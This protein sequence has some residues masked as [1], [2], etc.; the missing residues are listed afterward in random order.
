MQIK[1]FVGFYLL[2]VTPLIICRIIQ[3]QCKTKGRSSLSSFGPGRY[4][5]QL[6]HG[7]VQSNPKLAAGISTNEDIEAAEAPISSRFYSQG[8]THTPIDAVSSR[9]EIWSTKA[10]AAITTEPTVRLRLLGGPSDVPVRLLRKKASI[11]CYIIA[12]FW[13]GYTPYLQAART[14]F[15]SDWFTSLDIA[16][17]AVATLSLDSA[18]PSPHRS[19]DFLEYMGEFM[20]FIGG[21]PLIPIDPKAGQVFTRMTEK[22][23]GPYFTNSQELE[24]RWRSIVVCLSMQRS[25]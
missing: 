9:T 5:Q 24:Y 3:Q 14:A 12:C 20:L 2:D 16:V 6:S 17:L 13:K 4:L 22:S 23:L 10:S 18:L 19:Y 25:D 1:E 8:P 15:D 21:S 11:A 7:H